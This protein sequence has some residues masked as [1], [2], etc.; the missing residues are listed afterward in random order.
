MKCC[1][2]GAINV[3]GNHL[4]TVQ[5]CR[6]CLDR[7]LIRTLRPHVLKSPLLR[8][9]NQ[10]IEAVLPKRLSREEKEGRAILIMKASNG[11]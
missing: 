9:W 5:R 10:E 4:G 7:L 2:C 11:T 1:D 6:R 3:P 8:K